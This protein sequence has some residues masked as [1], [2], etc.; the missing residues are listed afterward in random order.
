MAAE[1]LMQLWWD[2]ARS[3]HIIVWVQL[4]TWQSKKSNLLGIKKPKN[5]NKQRGRSS[6]PIL[7]AFIIIASP[8]LQLIIPHLAMCQWSVY[9]NNHHPL[10][11]K[12]DERDEGSE[13]SLH[14]Y[15]LIY[16]KN[17]K[18]SKCC[19]WCVLGYCW[20]DTTQS[21]STHSN[22]FNHCSIIQN[23]SAEECA[24]L[25]VQFLQALI[26]PIHNA[27][28]RFQS[29]LSMDGFDVHHSGRTAQWFELALANTTLKNGQMQMP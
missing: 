25:F 2:N 1:W 6:L 11:E 4:V 24:I 19:L 15:V 29:G 13:A 21:V 27:R 28:L 3:S 26:A 17:K 20:S 8:P 9:A 22:L 12:R 18:K 5:N 16:M 14:K 23:Q 10:R 7:T